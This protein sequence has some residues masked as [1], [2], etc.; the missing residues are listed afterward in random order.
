M[1]SPQK[2]NGH[3][4]IANEL[5]EAF[6]LH[7]FTEYQR[8]IVLFLWRK[9]YGWSKKK[10]IIANSQFVVGTGIAK[11]KVWETIK[12]L[13][14]LGVV[15]CAGYTYSVNKNWEEWKVPCRGNSSTLHRV[16]KYPVEEDT[17]EKRK[18]KRNNA[19]SANTK[20]MR[21]HTDEDPWQEPAIDVETG[22]SANNTPKTD[23]G[24]R[25]NRLLSKAEKDRGKK[26]TNVMKQRTM[27]A[28][29]FDAGY[30][31]SEIAEMW[32]KLRADEWWK[33]KGVDFATVMSQLDKKQ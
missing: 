10:D 15:H 3:T 6:Y 25:M 11:G 5:L 24:A 27:I 18:I 31:A 16:Q 1:A 26:F 9:T 7:K 4:A 32:D 33:G 22:E 19:Q 13:K 23:R 29:M 8:V 28:R 14:D 21:T 2:E 17:K 30:K 12:E 20:T